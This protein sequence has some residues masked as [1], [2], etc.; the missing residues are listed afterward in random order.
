M[1]WAVDPVW[2]RP[3]TTKIRD[4]L[5]R[6]A[7]TI[8]RYEPVRMLAPPGPLLRAAQQEFN[9]CANINVLDA[10]VS[11][12]WMRDIMPTFAFR[13][14]GA[15]REVVAI[16]WHFNGWGRV[17]PHSAVAGS[18]LAESAAVIFGVPR[19]EASFVAEG[20]ALVTDGNGTMIVTRSC[21]L[22]S[23]RNPLRA[24]IDRQTEIS[25]GLSELGVR[26][27]IW[28]EGDPCE[29]ITSGHADGYVLCAP[30][31]VILVEA[32][33][34]PEVDSPFWREHDIALLE[35]ARNTDDFPF[36]IHRINSPRERYC[37]GDPE[38]FAA[39]YANAYIAN[40][41]VIAARFGDAERDEL[42]RQAL[43]KAFPER[44]IIMLQ[45]DA[46]A[47]GGGGVHCVTQQMPRLI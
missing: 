17:P 44:D 39:S 22:N 9:G 8:A 45:I 3:D 10:P 20:G 37:R 21:L 47:N 38:Y 13:S 19:I 33:D 42:A 18:G 15:K 1:S 29:P 6:I 41:A 2:S 23:N 34:D 25:S 46:I 31:N 5:S 12:F 40:G 7:H 35:N 14:L 43:A 28:L 16:D 26:K 4:A 30:N 36:T 32:V 24:G 27:V 11:D